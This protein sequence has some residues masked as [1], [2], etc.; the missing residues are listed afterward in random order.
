MPLSLIPLMLLIVPILE[1]T[2]F[3]LVGNLIGLWPTL[4][5]V[6]GSAI[7]GALLLRSQGISTLSRIQKEVAAGR[8]PGREMVHGVMIVVA[9][10]LL[11]TPGLI[12]DTIGYL[13]FVPAI[14]DAGWR[15][16][17]GRIVA[18]PMG[19]GWRRDPAAPPQPMPGVVELEVEDFERRPASPNSPWSDGR[20]GTLH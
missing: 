5:L 16:L 8:M 10:V 14:R 11:L 4:G 2:V 20:G 6:I 7:L 17:K 9:G 13:L 18:V 19:G 1:I 12:T 15:F 3:L